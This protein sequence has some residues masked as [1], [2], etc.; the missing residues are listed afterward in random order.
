LLSWFILTLVVV[1]PATPLVLGF[2]MIWGLIYPPCAEAGLA[3]GD[4][5]FTYEDVT[6]SARAGGSFRG[7]FVPGSNRAAIIVV[8]AFNSGRAGR[9]REAMLL[10][11]HGYSVFTFESRRCAGMGGLSLGYKEVD[12]VA[13]ALDYLQ[14]RPEVD[15]QRIGVYGFS[16]AGATAIMA[17]ARLPQ[18]RAVVAEG[19]Y[20]DFPEETLTPAADRSGLGGY[21]QTTF[22]WSA[23]QFYGLMTGMDI[24]L[25]SPVDVIGRISPRPILLI[26]GSREVSLIGGQRQ[27][28]AA[29]KNAELWVVEGAGHGNYFDVAPQ[30]YE[31]RLA[32][33]FDRSLG[34]EK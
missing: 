7:Y 32:T 13:D 26:Y 34:P 17:T 15:P 25:L 10:A 1:L 16:S 30:E 22:F 28:A 14:A 29:G 6:L 5:G 19:G 31:T 18:L 4:F 3:P 2:L 33:F 8:P 21:F 23:R 11:R 27:Q 20:G 12:E 9:L 24:N